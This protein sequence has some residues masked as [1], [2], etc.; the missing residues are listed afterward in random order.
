[1]ETTAQHGVAVTPRADLEAMPRH[2][3]LIM[4]GNRRWA[5]AHGHSD[6]G[7]GH[8]AG[9]EHLTDLLQWLAPRGIDHA[10]AYVLSADNIR[11]RSSLEV[12]FLFRLIENVIP[13][14]V[15]AAERWRLHVSG[16]LDLL[17]PTTR[18]ALL[19]AVDETCERP[20]HLTLAIGYDARS[21]ILAALRRAVTALP[22]TDAA[23]L[24]V[25]AVS[26][27]LSGGPT[28]Q[29]D[30]II[31][32]GGDARISGFFPWQSTRAELYVAQCAW[33]DFREPD[34][35]AALAHYAAVRTTR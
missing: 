24:S 26:K 1:M 14:R 28:K 7:A 4:D 25:E 22:G 10:S 16:D 30:L 11:K 8:R 34:L 2:V 6:V 18:Q 21:D 12:G 20:G 33:P 27:H 3:G 31:R 32:T 15:R 23:D 29:I 17:P 13:E 5:R 9:A 35:D 19:D